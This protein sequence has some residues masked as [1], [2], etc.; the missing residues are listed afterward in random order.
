M[1]SWLTNKGTAIYQ[2]LGG[3]SN[4][5]LLS[6]NN[7]FLLID[8]STKNNWNNLEKKI[9][10]FITVNETLEALILTHVHFDHAENASKI[11][12][13]YKAKIIVH[14]IESNLLR[15]GKNA[16]AG[17]AFPITGFLFNFLNGIRF[18][19]LIHFEPS[20]FDIAVS[21]N[22]H[23]AGFGFNAYTI[24]TPGHTSGSTSVIVD[25]EIAVAGDAL[26]GVFKNSVFSPWASNTEL[27]I[28]SWK[29][30]L[31]TNC[32]LYLPSHGASIKR[33]LLMKQYEKYSP[34][35]NII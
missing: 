28:K 12:N 7:K 31:D 2:I 17:G 24:H 35:Y 29:I 5:F 23:L 27:M 14:E 6:K 34:K 21:D 15:A 16:L 8:T 33:P 26:F 13:K 1:N 22:F 9:D 10:T 19:D 4:V 11:K 20:E 30:L 18:L 3:R 25:D 32:N